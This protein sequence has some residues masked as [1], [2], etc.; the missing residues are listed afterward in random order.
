MKTETALV[1]MSNISGSPALV[2]RRLHPPI[3]T[4]KPSEFI[5]KAMTILLRAIEAATQIRPHSKMNR[6]R[7]KS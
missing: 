4:S 6:G 1:L 7:I 2:R 5:G 3:E